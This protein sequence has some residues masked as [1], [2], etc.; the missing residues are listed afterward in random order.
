MERVIFFVQPQKSEGALAWVLW[1]PR[2]LKRIHLA[3]MKVTYRN[4]LNRSRPCI[5]LDSKI[6]RLVLAVFPKVLFFGHFFLDQP[7]HNGPNRV[8]LKDLNFCQ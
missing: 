3:P 7:I 5:I 2:I 1:Y 4:Y 6:P 8:I